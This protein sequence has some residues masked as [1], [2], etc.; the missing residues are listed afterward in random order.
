MKQIN[1]ILL[2]CFIALAAGCSK[3]ELDVANPNQ[4]DYKKVYKTGADLENLSSGLYTIV[5]DGENAAAGM[6]NMLATAADNVT[7]SWGN[8]GLRDMSF[9]P[10]DNS[11]DNSP[12]YS[13]AGLTEYTFNKMYAA[14]TTASLIYFAVDSGV[15]VEGAGGN[16]KVRA[17]TKFIQGVAYGNLSLL[18]DKAFLVDEKKTVEPSVTKA[19]GYLEVS[20]AAVAYLDTAIK[21]CATEFTIP[22]AWLGTADDYS[23]DDLKK[24]CNTL[25][26]RILSYVPRNKT[27][28]AAVDWTKVQAYAAA[29]ITSDFT[30][31]MDGAVNWYDEAGDY[32]TSNGWGMT[33]M[34]TVNMMDPVTQPA[35]W[36]NS[37]SFPR[38]PESTNPIDKR[39]KSDFEFVPSNWFNAGRGYY[40]FSTYRSKR[41]DDVYVNAIGPK[42]VILAAENVLLKAEAAAYKGALND[43][44]TL[45]NTG[46]RVTRGQMPV[47]APD[48]AKLVEAIHHE[49]FVELYTTGIGLQYFEMRKL[50]LLQKGTPLHLPLPAKVL[51]TFGEKPPYYTFGTVAKA[52]GKNTSNGGWR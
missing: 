39:L 48:L 30:I 29:G 36:D 13:N 21:Y 32:L 9:E 41:Y 7:C 49:R 2:T 47:V 19:V 52:D 40:H 35:H 25:A 50:D 22:A 5:Y 12:T 6:K 44:A 1:I 33:D 3:S 8:Y 17:F 51:Q 31:I 42:P 15:N 45:I 46:T 4:P 11:W 37:A 24:L 20:K 10:R 18:F 27:D 38:P 28:L 14:I 43:A 16:E 34:Y 26:A 23:N